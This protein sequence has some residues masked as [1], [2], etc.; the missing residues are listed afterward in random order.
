M[1]ATRLP[2]ARFSVSRGVLAQRLAERAPRKCNDINDRSRAL[3][4]GIALFGVAAVT[5]RTT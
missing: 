5:I 2:E 4:Y 1:Q 3:V